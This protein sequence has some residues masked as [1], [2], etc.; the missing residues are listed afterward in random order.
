MEITIEVC[1]RCRVEIKDV[2]GNGAPYIQFPHGDL[3]EHGVWF[4]DVGEWL[5]FA[6]EKF[7]SYQCMCEYM[8]IWHNA[9][10]LKK[11]TK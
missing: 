9:M 8:D 2:G 1:D 10:I 4:G 6:G 11:G 7:C 5:W 3:D